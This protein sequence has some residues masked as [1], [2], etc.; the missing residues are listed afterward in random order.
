MKFGMRKP[1]PLKSLS[2]M[3]K[4]RATRA[5]KKALI[6]GYGQKGMG[7]FNPKKALYN[8]VYNKTT[9][10]IFDVTKGMGSTPKTG[11]NSGCSV[12]L[13]VIAGAIAAALAL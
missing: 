10:S 12:V 4:G 1:S 6:P 13:I 3:T 2:A 8:K 9:F 7:L 11:S 5:I